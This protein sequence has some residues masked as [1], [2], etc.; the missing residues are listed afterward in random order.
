[1]PARDVFLCHASPD[2]AD[3]ARPLA[4]SL[5]REGVSVWLDEAVLQAGDSIV[6][7]INQGLRLASYVVVIVT[8]ELLSRPWPR[9]ELNAAFSREVRLGKVVIIPVLAVDHDTWAEEFPLLADKLFLSWNDGQDSIAREVAR[10]FD[11]I[12]AG[13]WVFLHPTDYV[14]PVWTRCTPTSDRSHSLTLRWGPLL[15]SVKWDAGECISR[16]LVHHKVA[17]DQ[18]PLHVNV[19]PPAIVTVGQGPPPDSAPNATN[20]DEGWTRAAGAPIDIVSAPSGIPLAS[21]RAQ[22]ADQLDFS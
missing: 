9:K 22:L 20:I 21:E 6:D 1:M 10:R 8:P 4:S 13:D 5:G 7:A 12:P 15:R 18:V 17:A 2:K 16:S 19:D 14:G 11:R 3:F